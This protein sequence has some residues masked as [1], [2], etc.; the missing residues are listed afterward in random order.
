MI[1]FSDFRKLLLPLLKGLPIIL[2]CTIVAGFLANRSTAYM[3]PTYEST[4]II[5]LD[6]KNVG[7][8]D[9]KLFKDFDLFSSS[10]KI[11]TEVEV[12]KSMDLIK[13]AIADTDLEINLSREG[14]IKSSLLLNESPFHIEYSFSDT[15]FFGNKWDLE[16]KQNDEFSLYNTNKKLDLKGELGDSIQSDGLLLIIGKNC[17]LIDRKKNIHIAGKYSLQIQNDKQ[18]AKH[19]KNNGLD[20]MAKDK[21]VPVIRISFSSSIPEKASRV[22]NAIAREYATDNV[23]QKRKAA[24]STL[25]FVDERMAKVSKKLRA[26]EEKLEKYKLQNSIIDLDIQSETD[27]RKIA[28]LELQLDN[29]E[30]NETALDELNNYVQNGQLFEESAPHSGF[31]DLLFTE[32]V[33]KLQ[34][35]HSKKTELLGSLTPEH[36]D[37]LAIDRN[38][39]E[40]NGYLHSSIENTR[41]DLRTKAQKIEAA[42]SEHQQKIANTPSQQKSLVILERDFRH[43][44]DTYN[45]LNQKRMEAAIAEASNISFHRIL[46]FGETPKE[47]SSPNTKFLTIVGGFLGFTFGCLISYLFFFLFG[48]TKDSDTLKTLAP[49][50][51]VH[52]VHQNSGE[53]ALLLSEFSQ[54]KKSSKSKKGNALAFV[55]LPKA[56]PNFHKATETFTK[57]GYRILLVDIN[58]P[59]KDSEEL[60]NLLN[61]DRFDEQIFGHKS[62]FD[63]I[64]ENP[65]NRPDLHKNFSNFIVA[66]KQN[67]DLVI[68][69]FP[70]ISKEIT[71]QA[72]ASSFQQHFFFSKG[73]SLSKREIQ[74]LKRET[75]ASL[76]KAHLILNQKKPWLSR[77]AQLIPTKSQGA[78]KKTSKALAG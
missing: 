62:G 18:V 10:H 14:K 63:Y 13:N 1:D 75:E 29:I 78:S 46:Q 66:Q 37:V 53:F 72:S 38:I 24:E 19:I 30:M 60:T 55:P 47:A 23:A 68:V 69:A 28:Q 45:F 21:D 42:I 74:F 36:P 20:I 48:G 9:T 34:S 49:L 26:A 27:L 8:G 32:M 61:S 15:S 44:N 16:V 58:H 51:S 41:N 56:K 54:H 71:C 3:T 73:S 67:Y 77:G 11:N 25:E 5:K 12:L 40:I 22:V 64:S 2:L 43:Y 33:K 50:D 65:L 39:E 6:D 7:L 31:G 52:R 76:K 57:A 35:Y 4:A 70:Q 59:T 17:D